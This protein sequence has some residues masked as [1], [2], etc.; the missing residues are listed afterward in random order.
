MRK[1]SSK[2]EPASQFERYFG[3]AI[4]GHNIHAL[5]KLLL[6]KHHGQA[7]SSMSKRDAA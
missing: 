7:A 5:G 6:A 3:F 2:T 4:L 1:S